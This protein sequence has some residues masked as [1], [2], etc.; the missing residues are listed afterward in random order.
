MNLEFICLIKKFK[1]LY[2]QKIKFNDKNKAL[3]LNELDK[4]LEDNIFKIEKLAG[5]FIKEIFLIIE[6]ENISE[7][8]FGIR[9]KL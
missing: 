1:N 2:K 7:I 8:N 5:Y 4:F 6:N 9:K 3:D